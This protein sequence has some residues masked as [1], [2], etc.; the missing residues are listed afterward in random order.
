MGAANPSD[1]VPTK[2]VYERWTINL[3]DSATASSAA[4][5]DSAPSIYKK[6]VVAMRSLFTYT[7]Y[8][9]AWR[10]GRR[11]GRQGGSGPMLRPRYRLV[12]SSVLASSASDTLTC[13]L[14]P[15]EEQSSADT[16]QFA[17]LNCLFGAINVAVSYRRNCEF[18]VED[19]ERLLSTKAM[20]SSHET[21]RTNLPVQQPPQQQYVSD[22]QV[23]S[24]TQRLSLDD[25]PTQDSRRTRIEGSSDK[26]IPRPASRLSID[27]NTT[28]PATNPSIDRRPSV[29]FQ[30][31]KAGSLSSSPGAFAQSGSPGSNSVGRGSTYLA[32]HVRNRSSLTTLPQQALRAPQL[33]N[34]TAVTSSASSSP[35]PAPLQRYSSSF[36]NRKSRFPSSG[37][38]KNDDDNLSSGRGS[39]SSA[40]RNSGTLPGTEASSSFAHA[41]DDSIASFISMIDKNKGLQSFSKTD[42]ATT[43]QRTAAQYSKFHRMRDSTTQLTDSMSSSLMLHRSSS[44][45]SRQLHNVPGM[46]AGSSLSTSSSPGKP[47][48][49]HTPHLPAIPSRL[50]NNSIIADYSRSASRTRP[51]LSRAPNSRESDIAAADRPPRSHAPATSTAIDI[52]TSP[53]T[54]PTGRRSSSAAQQ[55][56][57]RPT[58]SDEGDGMPYGLRSASMP[59]DQGGEL[60]LSELL[61]QTEGSGSASGGR[62]AGG[63]S[64]GGGGGSR[65]RR[66]VT[67][68]AADDDD[69][70]LLFAL[71]E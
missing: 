24:G 3:D 20:R 14:S 42:Q 48:S 12:D 33:N 32:T 70:P 54:F 7:K 5:A 39:M 44:S 36:S 13:P 57:I 67:Q 18:L 19:T 11:L 46:V 26:P 65:R 1:P 9:P 50:S 45:S 27:S 30:P 60:S 15:A 34:E 35:K 49:P 17:P 47:I 66:E 29:S 41:D 52:P 68:P 55:G 71:A 2:L 28:R 62:G 23:T 10:F 69:E 59:N 16:F 63:A 22:A 53:R 43:S 21:R 38:I 56:R 37:N 6:G 25:R 8:L 58:E 64:G 61:S 51:V 31:F 4:V 40:H